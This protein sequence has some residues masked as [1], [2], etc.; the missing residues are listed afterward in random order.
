MQKEIMNVLE[1]V[2]PLGEVKKSD[3]KDYLDKLETHIEACNNLMPQEYKKLSS[4]PILVIEDFGTT[5][6]NGET[7]EDGRPQSRSNFYSFWWME[8]KSSKSGV[9][10]GRWG[11]GKT[12]F[13]LASKLRTFWGFTIRHNDPRR[14]LMGKALLKTHRMDKKVY[15]YHG[16]FKEKN[17]K[18]IEKDKDIQDFKHKFLITRDKEPGLSIVIPMPDKDITYS[19]VIQSVIIH[20]FYAIIKGMLEVEVNNNS[21]SIVLNR[22]KQV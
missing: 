14:L 9:E 3:I 2:F 10:G 16:Y 1:S 17:R 8:G 18:P 6:L 4:I 20:Y 22:N 12:T 7:G 13:H 5:G 11:L 15:G 21:N 19:A